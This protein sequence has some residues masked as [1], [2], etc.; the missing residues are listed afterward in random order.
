MF[1]LGSTTAL[2]QCTL[3]SPDTWTNLA[4]NG[5]W[6]TSGNWSV[7]VPTSS[8]NTCI[9]DGTSTVTSNVSGSTAD[10][11]LATGNILNF[12]PGTILSV[13]GTQIINAGQINVISGGGQNAALEL[14][15]N[16]TLSGNG[17][18]TLSNSG[19]GGTAFIYQ[20]A[21]GLTLTNQSTIQGAAD[22]GLNG[23]SLI[24]QGTVDANTS[25]QTLELVSMSNGVNNAG[26]LLRASNGGLLFV[27][28]ITV[29]GGGTITATTGGTVQ[30]VGNT[31]VQGGTLNNNGGTLGTPAG[32]SATLDGST[33]AG[34]ITINGTY[35]NAAGADTYA[36]GTINNTN[37][38]LMNSG[39]AL[40]GI[41]LAAINV[42]LQGGGTVT[43]CNC[44]RRRP[45]HR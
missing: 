20:A 21:G 27:D 25:G 5:D 17:K 39:V 19:G 13:F 22:I 36:L 45:G 14:E 43:L 23:L 28:G 6:N 10:L 40:I 31:V 24:N 16:V 42:T 29:G 4:L 34:A 18:L 32:N 12:D 1:C 37:N 41:V 33:A 8:T 26:G 38:F 2:A 7:S 44:H 9:T 11:Q 3:T 15:N 35:L 30:L